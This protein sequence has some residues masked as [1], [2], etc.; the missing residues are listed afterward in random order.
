MGE[1]KAFSAA[2]NGI[3]SL[4]QKFDPLAGVVILI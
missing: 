2:E 3:H 4:M 1:K